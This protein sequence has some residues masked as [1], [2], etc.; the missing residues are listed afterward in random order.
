VTH[1]NFAGTTTDAAG[2]DIFMICAPIRPGTSGGLVIDSNGSVLGMVIGYDTDRPSIGLVLPA[3][4]VAKFLTAHGGGQEGTRMAP[5]RREG[6]ERYLR[7]VSVL[8]QC[9]PSQPASRFT[10][11]TDHAL[12]T[13]RLG[14]NSPP[15]EPHSDLL[16][17]RAA[18]A[19]GGA[20]KI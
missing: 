16:E 14:L 20:R 10:P 8:V 13:R 12:Q 15:A 6:L 1:G 19:R 17:L 7:S 3:S 5:H 4:V 18:G 11:P 2:S 9:A